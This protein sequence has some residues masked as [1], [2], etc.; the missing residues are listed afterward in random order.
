MMT[1][2]ILIF[3]LGM[4]RYEKSLNWR[5]ESKFFSLK[6]LFHSEFTVIQF[7][8]RSKN[9]SVAAN[10]TVDFVEFVAHV[11]VEINRVERQSP[12]VAL[13]GCQLAEMLQIVAG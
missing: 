6:T 1:T 12:T 9:S 5:F 4:Q 13:V 10:H 8:K 7:G 3:N 2:F 11:K